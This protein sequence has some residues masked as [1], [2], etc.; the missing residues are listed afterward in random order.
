MKHMMMCLLLSCLIS[1]L[2]G[3]TINLVW[4]ANPAAQ[5]V[6][7]YQPY[8]STTSGS[9]YVPIGAPV[10]VTSFSDTVADNGTTY[11]YV[12]KAL[13][14]TEESGFSNE[15]SFTAPLPPLTAPTNLRLQ[16]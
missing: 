14:G 7:G 16:P 6:T 12:V 5:N 8:R 1:N 2:F 13:R 9:G 4:D 3:A 15:F 10:I 11:Y